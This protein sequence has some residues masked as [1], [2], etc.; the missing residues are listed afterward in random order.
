MGLFI[1]LVTEKK[2]MKELDL[3]YNQFVTRYKANEITVLVDIQTAHG[4]LEKHGPSNWRRTIKILTFLITTGILAGIIL[5]F[6]VKWWIP[7]IIFICCGWTSK[8]IR[9]ESQKALIEESLKSSDLFLVSRMSG[10]F[11]FYEK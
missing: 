8:A 6:F 1:N 4:V 11:K 9:E 5:F 7:I 3:S 2:N 10:C